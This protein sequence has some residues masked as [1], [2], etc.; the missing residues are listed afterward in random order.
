VVLGQPG[1]D[2]AHKPLEGTTSPDAAADGVM[3]LWLGGE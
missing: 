3:E 2:I 1:V